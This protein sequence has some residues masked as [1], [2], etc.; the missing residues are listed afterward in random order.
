MTVR[1]VSKHQNKSSETYRCTGTFWVLKNNFSSSGLNCRLQNARFLLLH[2]MSSG[3]ILP[4]FWLKYKRKATQQRSLCVCN[5]NVLN[6]IFVS[7][8]RVYVNDGLNKFSCV[9]SFFSQQYPNFNA[10]IT[11]E[12]VTQDRT[13]MEDQIR[14]LQGTSELF[15]VF[16]LL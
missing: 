11:F 3:Y 13:K 2:V 15:A 4:S 8:E 6:Q 1:G 16:E 10:D 7:N 5:N 12:S 14:H 9:M